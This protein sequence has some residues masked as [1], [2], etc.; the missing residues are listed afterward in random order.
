MATLLPLPLIL[1]AGLV[2]GILTVLLVLGAAKLA[3][4]VPPEERSFLDPLPP[5]LRLIW[6][7]VRLIAT[8]LGRIWPTRWLE[9]IHTRL[10][11]ASASYLFHPEEFLALMVFAALA[12]AFLAGFSAL[13]IGFSPWLPAFLGLVA[14]GLPLLW[15]R[16]RRQRRDRLILRTFPIFLD[17]ITLGV[18]AGLNFAGA[19]QQAIDNGPEGIFQ[20]ELSHVLGDIKSGITRA[21]ALRRLHERVGLAEVGAFVAAINQAERTGGSLGRVLRAQSVRARSERFQRAEK[22]AMEAPVKLLAP[23][24]LFIFPTTFLVIA[25]PIAELFL[26]AINGGG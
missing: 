17:F 19:L 23:L 4:T 11:Q 7:V 9:W 6:P 10:R 24:V 5:L 8:L 13:M 22:A 1:F 18:E 21:Q 3:R 16:E 20:Q 15:L 14:G 2:A 26:H 12:G 25:F